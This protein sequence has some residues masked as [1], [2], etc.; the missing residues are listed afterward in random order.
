M[1]GGI[2]GGGDGAARTTNLLHEKSTTY[3]ALGV[4]AALLLALFLAGRVMVGAVVLNATL[5]ER[6]TPSSSRRTPSDG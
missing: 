1:R 3:G 2:G 5:H 6:R 4:A